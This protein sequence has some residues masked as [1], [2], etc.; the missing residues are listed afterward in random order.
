M[1]F[2]LC[3]VFV[4]VFFFC[5]VV[6]FADN[7]DFFFGLAFVCCCFVFVFVVDIG[8]VWLLLIF[9]SFFPGDFG[10]GGEAVGAVGHKWFV[11]VNTD[12]VRTTKGDRKTYALAKWPVSL[13]NE[14]EPEPHLLETLKMLSTVR[15]QSGHVV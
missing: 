2:V 15:C 13:N 14:V 6:V 11:L 8:L 10:G 3:F 7:V 9:M 1:V 12:N 4:G 5:F